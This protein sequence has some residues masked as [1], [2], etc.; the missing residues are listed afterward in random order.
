MRFS[1]VLTALPLISSAFAYESLKSHA[2]GIKIGVAGNTLNFNDSA[3]MSALSN[4]NYM[5]AENG[6]KLPAIQGQRGVYN[7]NDCDAHLAK[8]KE[9]GMT[10]RGHCLIW[11]AYQPAWFES[12][13]GDDL[14]KAIVDHITTVLKH[15]DGKIDAWDVVNEAI[16]DNSTGS[17][18]KLRSSFLSQNVPDFID[19]AFKTARSV[20]PSTKLFYNDYSADGIYAKTDAVFNFVKDLKSRNIPID[21]VGLQ[22]H[23]STSAYGHPSYDQVNSLLGRY[24]QLGVEVHIT[25]MDVKCEGNES[26][27]PQIF[28]DALRACLNNSCCKAFLVWGVGDNDSWLG[29]SAK[30]LLFDGTY[31]PKDSYFALIKALGGS[32]NSSNGNQNQNQNQNNNNQW[33]QNQNQNQNNNNQ[34]N[35]N[36]NQ[37]N[38]NNNNQNQNQNNN[39][40]NNAVG[41]NCAGQW[42]QCGG[43]GFNGPSC[44]S[45][46]TCKQINE[47]YSQCQ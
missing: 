43:I 1:T 10:F 38:N 16:D 28:A 14:K 37:N 44:C 2:N 25:E 23:V 34:W 21:G 46:G 9:L 22:Y 36:Q 29:G 7:F 19:I 41:G 26:Q 6:C 8:A 20:S 42:A 4:F 27:Q 12:L 32:G 33:N 40:Q 15:Y 18:W 35:Q 24:C 17:N 30:G 5:V 39:N 31:Q 45:Q 11:H 3:Y 13:R 47:Y